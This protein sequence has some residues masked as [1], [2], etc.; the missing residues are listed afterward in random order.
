MEYQGGRLRHG[1]HRGQR[2]RVGKDARRSRHRS[3]QRRHGLSVRQVDGEHLHAD[4][5]S[6]RRF[7]R[8]GGR[9][10]RGHRQPV[11]DRHLREHLRRIG[12][13]QDVAD[14]SDEDRLHVRRLEER[15]HDLHVRRHR[16]DHGKY[17][18]HGCMD[19]EYLRGHAERQRRHEHEPHDERN[20]DLRSRHA[21]ADD[22]ADQN[23]LHVRRLL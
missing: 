19:G 1:H 2:H 15:Q 4:V 13:Q 6:E 21:D 22:R 10:L 9:L 7:D 8:R 23:G 3:R 16:V 14:R 5:Q 20:G 17:D 12:R 11:E 18:D